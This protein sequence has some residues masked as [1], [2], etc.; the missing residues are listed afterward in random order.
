VTETADLL[1][2]AGHSLLFHPRFA[3]A[4]KEH[5]SRWL[6]IALAWIYA[7]MGRPTLASQKRPDRA[8]RQPPQDERAAD[9]RRSGRSGDRRSEGV[10][11]VAKRRRRCN[12]QA[13]RIL[14]HLTSS[15][16]ATTD[17]ELR[18]VSARAQINLI[19]ASFTTARPRAFVNDLRK[20]VSIGEPAIEAL[21]ERGETA[22]ERMG[23]NPHQVAAAALL[24][25]AILLEELDRP[26][27]AAQTAAELTGRF[28]DDN[29]LG[30]RVLRRLSKP[31]R[32][33]TQ[34][35]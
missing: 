6:A 21:R 27:E 31:H 10:R 30:M 19:L 26:D 35:P 23:T 3:E 2:R 5:Q 15:V 11:S 1:Q 22:G 28:R 13:H 29:S 24:A 12:E 33:A 7:G 16:A 20:L 25:E 14:A 8:D 34:Y 9:I 32:P 18:A 4:R 17:P